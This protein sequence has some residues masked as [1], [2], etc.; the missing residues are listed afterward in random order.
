MTKGRTPAPTAAIIDAQ[1][2]KTSG[3]VGESSQGIDAGKKIKGR[4]R[5]IATDT[6]NPPKPGA[7]NTLE[8]TCSSTSR[9]D[10]LLEVLTE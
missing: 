1:S 3:N 6:E 10:A 8:R 4:K 9:S 5:H 2:V 7:S